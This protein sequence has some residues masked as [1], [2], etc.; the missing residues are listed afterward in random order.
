MPDAPFD[1]LNLPAVMATVPAFGG[2]RTLAPKIVAQ[3][4][5]HTQYFEP[6]ACSLA[7]LFGKPQ[8]QK[9][10]IN[11]L[12]GDIINLNRV[13]REID[14]AEQ[15]YDR[16]QQ[17]TMGD[18]ILAR[19]K[20]EL[21]GHFPDVGITEVLPDRAY[22]YFIACWM[23]RNGTAGTKRLDYQLAVRWT[24]GGGS[25]TVRFRNAVESIPW[26]HHRLKNVVI[27]KR[28]AFKI[29]NCFED[30][31]ATCI[32]C[33]P[34]YHAGTRSI[35]IKNGQGGLYL[36]E[37]DHAKDHHRLAEA[38]RQYKHARIIVSY[39]DSP[40]IR[41]LYEGWSVLECTMNKQLHQQNGR[42]KR[43]KAAPEILLING[44]LYSFQ[45]DADNERDEETAE[46]A[47]D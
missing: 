27:L 8:S 22:W 10:T 23:G 19:A 26:W 4:G 29:M 37:F 31:K 25:P 33:D 35:N 41:Q 9:E 47:G 17:C 15:L 30:D 42:G 20:H 3:M 36:H 28:D 43:S 1:L 24:K 13:I 6:F 7:V 40:I 12:H 21:A 45:E 5:K 32:Y 46:A 2:K 34:P 38:L 16:L 18:D 39:Y 44:P 14:L 11:D